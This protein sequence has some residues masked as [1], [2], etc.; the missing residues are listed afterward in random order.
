MK[1]I[2][3]VRSGNGTSRNDNKRLRG[4]VHSEGS[5]TN[6]GRGKF[7]PKDALSR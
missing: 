6:H 7:I 3:A 1:E 2:E 5:M 4:D